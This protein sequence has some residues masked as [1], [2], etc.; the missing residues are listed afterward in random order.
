MLLSTYTCQGGP[1]NPS[2]YCNEEYDRAYERQQ[3]L[4]DPEER[5][6]AVREL[7]QLAIDTHSELAVVYPN[8]TYAHSDGW[9]GFND[10]VGLGWFGGP[11]S[12]ALELAP[13]SN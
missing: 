6:V 5:L 2:G 9:T 12:A 4:L 10:T 1:F 8:W 3:R 7:Q 11:T 13:A